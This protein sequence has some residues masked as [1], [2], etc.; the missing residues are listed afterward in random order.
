[1][2]DRHR[3]R[4]RLGILLGAFATLSTLSI[5][6]TVLSARLVNHSPALLLALAPANRHLLLT[7]A[8][9]INPFA[10]VLAAGSRYVIGGT[11]LYLLGRDY[12]EACRAWF[13]RQPGG[14]PG[15]VRWI[16]KGFDA[17]WWA[18]VPV[19]VGSNAARL[20]AGARNV[21]ARTYAVLLGLGITGRLALFWYLG[22]R[23]KESLERVLDFI[24][25]YQW[26]IIAA[27]VVV[28]VFQSYRKTMAAERAKAA[29]ADIDAIAAIAAEEAGGDIAADEAASDTAAASEIDA[30]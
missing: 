13:E 17:A 29:L 21:P 20:L 7:S 3:S 10:Y 22:Q 14:L 15:S 6:G 8:A 2:P 19:M 28:T 23:F 24:D 26:W 25:R 18:V 16:E 1:M 5:V 12:G 11:V 30:S 4:R 27:F 9:G